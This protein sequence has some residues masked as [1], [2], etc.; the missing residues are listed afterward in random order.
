MPERSPG[1]YV[2]VPFCASRCGYCDF[3]SVV[4][5]ESVSG[6]LDALSAES[7]IYKDEFSRFG[8]LYIG[9]GTPSFL[10]RPDLER[11]ALD[12][13]DKFKFEDG[14][15]FTLEAN[16]D[17]LTRD[18]LGVLR[19]IGVNRLSIGVQSFDDGELRILGRRH[20]AASAL[21]A[22]EAVRLAGFG[23]IGIDL[24][25]AIPGQ[26]EETLR[27]TLEQAL[28]FEPEHVSCYELTLEPEA[29]LARA[30]DRGEVVGVEEDVGRDLFTM[31]S[32]TLA[33][34]GYVHYEVSNY[35]IDEEHRSKH[36]SRYWDQSPYLGLGPS[37]HSLSSCERR[38]N[39]DD[40]D[41][42]CRM[43]EGGE[44]PVA[45]RE[46]LSDSQML[47]ERLYFGFRTIEGF[48]LDFFDSLP[49]G[50]ETLAELER[51]SLVRIEKGRVV[52]TLRGFLL[53]DRLPLLFSTD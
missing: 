7:N 18:K 45:G 48:P 1:L 49:G 42:Y 20:D 40:V 27:A 28:S 30:I 41:R 22:V 5:P 43:L 33:G 51:T 46:T 12:I 38:W 37:A 13:L 23:N 29:P 10:M 32:E 34:Q 50:G 47:L 15:E 24:I 14:F 25:Y 39:I 2:H 16:P 36:N 53:S 3:Y 4:R 8:T 44:A 6:W 31:I 26:T 17:D 9:G 52:P 11:L 21:D 35:A 19:D